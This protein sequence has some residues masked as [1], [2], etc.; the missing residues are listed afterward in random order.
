LKTGEALLAFLITTMILSPAACGYHD[1]E[2]YVTDDAGVLLM[3]DIYDIE[4]L[5]LEVDTATGAEIAVLIVPTTSPDSIETYAVKTFESSGIGQEGKDNGL[6]LLIAVEDRTWRIEVGYGL[7]GILPDLKVNDIGETF[8]APY[9]AEFNYYEGILFTVA[10]LGIIIVENYTGSP[11]REDKGPWYPI[12]FIPLNWWQLLIAV[13]VTIFIFIITGGRLLL[14][15]G[16]SFGG[17]RGGFGGGR[18]GGGG[19]GGR[20]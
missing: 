15:I 14:W 2:Y 6:L 4:D 8:L 5:C 9:L 10:E 7:E 18:S 13:S 20:F 11:P 17:G 12:S 1:L 3:Q 19:S 16:G